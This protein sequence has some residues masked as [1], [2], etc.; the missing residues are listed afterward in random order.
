MPVEDVVE[1]AN[2]VGRVVAVG[3]VVWGRPGGGGGGRTGRSGRPGGGRRRGG[4]CG[5]VRLLATQ[6]GEYPEHQDHGD[7]HH[8]PGARSASVVHRVEGHAL[9]PV[10]AGRRGRLA[11]PG[12]PRSIGR[13]SSKTIGASG[14]GNS[15]VPRTGTGGTTRSAERPDCPVG[16]TRTGR[17]VWR[18]D[19]IGEVLQSAEG[20]V[21]VPHRVD[22]V[23]PGST[24]QGDGHGHHHQHHDDERDGQH[25]VYSTPNRSSG[26]ERPVRRPGTGRPGHVVVP[27]RALRWRSR[28]SGRRRRSGG[29]R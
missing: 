21:V 4:V 7:G 3:R 1:A 12:R 2:W 5:L 27:V 14:S 15:S 18:P 9:G 28:R 22:V 26:V 19:A 25:P 17:T 29:P 8:D 10:G 24:D 6:E 20:V 23:A 16:T 11:A 13:A